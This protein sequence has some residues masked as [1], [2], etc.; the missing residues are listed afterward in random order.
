MAHVN[1]Q[2]ISFF[3][4]TS[5][6]LNCSYC[7]VNRDET[8]RR[9]QRLDLDFAIA[10]IDDF[11]AQNSSRHIRFFGA[12]EPTIE[13]DLIKSIYAYAYKKAGEDLTAEIQT[14][15][16]FSEKVADWLAENVN[17]I[18]IS[19]D[20]PP[21]VQNLNRFRK[22]KKPTSGILAKNI[23]HLIANGRGMTGIRSTVTEETIN[24]QK[25]LVDYFSFLGIK[26]IWSDP[27]FPSVGIK[28]DY[29]LFNFNLYA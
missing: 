17:I 22:N 23:R 9:N 25:E 2:M 10:G 18:W 19:S 20:G 5:C 6:N 13:F 21:D 1:K 28:S 12:G 29:K 3:V 26:Y 4:T 16:V 15:G 7:Y 8:E 14:N 11:F 24:R 27:L